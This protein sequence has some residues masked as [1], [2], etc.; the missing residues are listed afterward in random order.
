MK[1]DSAMFSSL[2]LA[3]LFTACWLGAGFQYPA[4]K[5]L[6]NSA[7][8]VVVILS[9]VAYAIC[10]GKVGAIHSRVLSPQQRHISVFLRILLEFAMIGSVIWIFE[11]TNHDQRWI[12]VVALILVASVEVLRLAWLR[13]VLRRQPV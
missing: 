1:N 2:T 10:L 9:F 13:R 12:G 7:L 4:Q 11:F 3:L 5:L 8:F 6:P